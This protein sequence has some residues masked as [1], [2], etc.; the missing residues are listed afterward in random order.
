M[1]DKLLILGLRLVDLVD[2]L[3][4]GE[5]ALRLGLLLGVCVVLVSS[6]AARALFGVVFETGPLESALLRLESLFFNH[7]KVS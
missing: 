4:N 7:G 2:G 6:C 3:L 1:G 5:L